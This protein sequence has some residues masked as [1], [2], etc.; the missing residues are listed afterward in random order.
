MVHRVS[1][2]PLASCAFHALLNVIGA[3]ELC[4]LSVLAYVSLDLGV[5]MCCS[6]INASNN[7]LSTLLFCDSFLGP[8]TLDESL[9]KSRNVSLLDVNLGFFN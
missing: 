2:N 7:S 1:S 8:T 4:P 3:E 5:G 9:G 6:G